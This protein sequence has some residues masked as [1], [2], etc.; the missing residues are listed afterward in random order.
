M[1]QDDGDE[2]G[3]QDEDGQQQP[4]PPHGD[5][6]D[7]GNTRPR[8]REGKGQVGAHCLTVQPLPMA[9][10]LRINAESA[11]GPA[12]GKIAHGMTALAVLREEETPLLH[13]LPVGPQERKILLSEAAEI[14]ADAA[15]QISGAD[16][17]GAG[18]EG[19]R[20]DGQAVAALEVPAHQEDG[21]AV[22]P[23]GLG[24]HPGGEG[25]IDRR[26]HG[27]KMQVGQVGAVPA[28]D[29]A[30]LVRERWDAPGVKGIAVMEVL[31]QQDLIVGH[32]GDGELGHPLRDARRGL[33]LGEGDGLG[34]AGNAPAVDA[35]QA[36][37]DII[38]LQEA[39]GI[40]PGHSPRILLDPGDVHQGIAARHGAAAAGDRLG[41]A[42]AHDAAHIFFAAEG[43][44]GIAPA[45]GS[46]SEPRDAAHI[47]PVFRGDGAIA[48]A[49]GDEAQI[50]LPGDAAGIAALAGD[51]PGVDAQLD[52]GL[53]LIFPP[54]GP[55][56]D[57]V[58]GIQLV[59]QGHGPGDAA[60]V[61]V[62]I[63]RAAVLAGP[64][65]AQGDLVHV[66]RRGVGNGGLGP[67]DGVGDGI[68]DLVEFCVDL[69]DVAGHGAHRAVDS[70]VEHGQL[71]V[72][73]VDR[74]GQPAEIGHGR[75]L[76]RAAHRPRPGEIAHVHAAPLGG[77]I[78][79][80][81]GDGPRAGSDA[82]GGNGRPG[83]SVELDVLRL[84]LGGGNI[85]GEL[86]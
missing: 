44:F 84:L 40:Q 55:G 8:P 66:H 31:L 22:L 16:A 19:L 35:R 39:P 10:F 86:I 47:A 12:G 73:A 82:P 80:G 61:E 26:H 27:V 65:L 7:G 46:A 28:G 83:R 78:P 18:G 69:A 45:H 49:V 3:R 64:G 38:I 71:T 36:V 1:P 43:A 56:G 6:G 76:C 51:L 33:E 70:P 41:D 29:G 81:D 54:A 42:A 17:E 23:E 5:G 11:G 74:G 25:G 58:L 48:L 32:E 4:R 34:L 50:H 37:T 30:L 85:A 77:V 57:I 63:D 68:G 2:N 9:V 20:R 59:F 21:P 79:G 24:G 53:V 62:A 14:G 13:R 72:D 60:H 52:H 75:D 15:A 67:G